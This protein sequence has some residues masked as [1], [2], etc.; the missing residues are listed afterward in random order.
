VNTSSTV[1]QSVPPADLISRRDGDLLRSTSSFLVV[2]IHCI[3]LWVKDFYAT[4]DFSSLGF[5][6]T[7]F[8][9]LSRFTVPAFFFL[10]GYGL[11]QQF[12][13][14]QKPEPLLTYYRRRLFK[15]SLPFFA[16]SALTIYRPWGALVA[17]P[18]AD[19]PVRALGGFFEVLLLRGFD[20]QY[21]FLIVIFQFY[22]IFPF[23]YRLGRSRLFVFL[24]LLIQ[25][26]VM[27]PIEGYLGLVGW[28]LPKLYSFLLL[29]YVFYF[30]AGIHAVWHRDL[31]AR[32]LAQTTR[33]QIWAFWFGALGLTVIEYW[34]NIS[35]LKKPLPYADHFNRWAVVVYCFA[36]FLLLLKHRERLRVHVHENPRWQ[37]LFTAFTPFSFFVYLAHTHFLRLANFFLYGLAP[38]L[39]FAR[40]AFVAGMSYLA[41]WSL[42]AL[43][44]NY[45]RVRFALGLPKPPL[46]R[47]DFPGKY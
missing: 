37:F 10:S 11:T 31:F 8:D 13:A 28:E 40:V 17:L 14:L 20:Y 12:R 23:I 21:Y 43:L 30:V 41:A 2:V 4:H 46:R 44:E 25:L 32:L 38:W 15:I 34:V 36:S 19:H 33:L 27:S 18:W 9:Q 47:K 24:C 5:V 3:S 26:P 7:L 22:L 39:L 45:P 1:P 35:V 6:A 42:Q 16:W 29:F